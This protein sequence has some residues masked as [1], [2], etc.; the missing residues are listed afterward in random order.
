MTHNEYESLSKKTIE[1]LIKHTRIT[2]SELEEELER[3]ILNNQ[4]S[5]IDHLEDHME[6]VERGFGN[7]FLLLKDVINSKNKKK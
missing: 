5:E 7:F 2:L 1:K 4:H 6:E 3:R